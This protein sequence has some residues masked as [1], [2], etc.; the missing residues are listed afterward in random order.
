MVEARAYLPERGDVVWL[1]FSPQSGHE[2]AGRRPALVLSPGAYNRRTGLG[3]LCPITSVVKGY[4]FE[5]PV[6]V[7]NVQGVVL[8]DQVR[9]L[10][11]RARCA[12]RIGRVTDLTLQEVLTRVHTL[13]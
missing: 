4:A 5:V 2:Q 12:E 1:Q 9:S 11:W 3:L 7:G 10:D 13:V 6:N 8:S